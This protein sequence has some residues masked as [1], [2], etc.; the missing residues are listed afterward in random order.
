ML[1][2]VII[3]PTTRINK[4]R[5]STNC[6]KSPWP[7]KT[8]WLMT[9]SRSPGANVF[10]RMTRNPYI[11][12]LSCAAAFYRSYSI[13][14][15]WSTNRVSSLWPWD[16]YFWS[17]NFLLSGPSFPLLPQPVLTHGPCAFHG[18]APFKGLCCR[19]FFEHCFVKSGVGQFGYDLL[20][21]LIGFVV[22]FLPPTFCV[23]GPAVGR[24]LYSQL[25]IDHIDHGTSNRNVHSSFES[26]TSH[27]GKPDGI[28]DYSLCCKVF[29]WSPILVMK[30]FDIVVCNHEAY[31]SQ[32][33]TRKRFFFVFSSPVPLV[34]AFLIVEEPWLS[35]FEIRHA[36]ASKVVHNWLCHPDGRK[37]V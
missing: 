22:V 10:L 16:W 19:C 21:G 30:W 13:R 37:E 27:S 11:C 9:V 12:I 14:C 23:D 24:V 36:H 2:S 29:N 20:K 35:R 28:L 25:V 15:W 1:N 3:F 18:N 17:C 7:L 31:A 4:L 26:Q 33:M 34:P 8:S 32:C 5:S 6:S